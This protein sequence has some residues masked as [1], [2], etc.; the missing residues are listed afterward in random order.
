MPAIFSRCLAV[1]AAYLPEFGINVL[2]AKLAI[3]CLIII[4]FI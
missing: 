3:I 2:I 1:V 4:V